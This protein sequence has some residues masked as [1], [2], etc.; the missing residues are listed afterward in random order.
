[1]IIE[2]SSLKAKVHFSLDFILI[3]NS[4]PKQCRDTTIR[5][6]SN[7]GKQCQH[8]TIKKHSHRIS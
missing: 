2:K 6:N 4:F 3:C 1:M 7:E 8:V 5:C